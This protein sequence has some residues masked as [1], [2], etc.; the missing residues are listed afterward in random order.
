MGYRDSKSKDENLG[1]IPKRIKKL[2]QINDE[3]QSE[4]ATAINTT[5]STIA[6]IEQGKSDPSLETAKNI[7]L[8]YKVSVDYIC[9]LSADMAIPSSTLDTLCRYIS[10]DTPIRTVSQSHTIPVISVRKCFLEYLKV[11]NRAEQLKK[12]GVPDEVLD[13]WLEKETEKAKDLLRNENPNIKYAL[14]TT[15]YIT[16]DDVLALLERA[17]NESSGED[18]PL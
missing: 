11:L 17:Y 14:L 6:N 9:G 10:L 1:E 13:A 16:S 15:R 12:G 7:A 3:T 8:H 5:K 18:T 4:L 2:R